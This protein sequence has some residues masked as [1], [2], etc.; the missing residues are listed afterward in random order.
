MFIYVFICL[1]PWSLDS[2]AG[3]NLQSWPCMISVHDPVCPSLH[4]RDFEVVSD[5]DANDRACRTCHAVSHAHYMLY[6]L[7]RARSHSNN[8]R[9]VSTGIDPI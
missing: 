7:G 8:D 3:S 1:K 2:F 6:I 9:A 4:L 5:E